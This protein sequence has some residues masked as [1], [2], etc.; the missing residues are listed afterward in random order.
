MNEQ[1]QYEQELRDNGVELP[2]LDSSDK[3][4]KP[5]EVDEPK[6][7]DDE[8]EEAE[9]TEDKPDN[10]PEDDDKSQKPAEKKKRSIYDEY[11]DKKAEVKT[12]RELREQ[13]ESERDDALAKLADAIKS[14]T[15]V[16]EKAEAKDELDAYAEEYGLDAQGVKKLQ[17]ILLKGVNAAPSM[18]DE[19]RQA[20][21]KA[22]EFVRQSE[23]AADRQ[24]FET[25]FAAAT[26]TLEQ[27][28]PGISDDDRNMV[29]KRIDELAHSQQYHDK[30]LDY[31]L[32]RNRDDIAKIITPRKRG[33][34][35]K[36]SK[37]Q[38]SN[39]AK[40]TFDPNA[41]I[42]KMSSAA[43]EAWEKEYERVTSSGDGIASGSNGRKLLL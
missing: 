30:E 33:L 16:D 31:I 22:K 36:G 3:G 37:D 43:F 13:A 9:E 35:S 20:V 10:E 40:G 34:E 38:Q 39:A 28:F 11:K 32:F 42:S 23:E 26:P 6:P 25:E 17:S 21:E 14:A 27:Y 5:K 41:D 24:R 7:Q 15:T 19:D 18:S 2:E 8:P 12:E 1:E 29:K 4:Q